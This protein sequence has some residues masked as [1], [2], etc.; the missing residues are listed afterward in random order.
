MQSVKKLMFVLLL[1]IVLHRVAYA[2]G[3]PERGESLYIEH[4]CYSCHGYNGI[5]RRQ[6]ANN[7]SP[8]MQSEE[9]FTVYLRLRA[10]MDPAGPSNS[11]PNYSAEVLSDQDAADLFSYISTLSDEPPAL[12]DIPVMIEILDAAREDGDAE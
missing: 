8:F 1:T 2:A 11:M 12:E 6:L 4:G 7:A 10:N 5:G 9:V 3:S